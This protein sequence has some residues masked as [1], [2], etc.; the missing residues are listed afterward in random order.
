MLVVKT[1]ETLFIRQVA[2]IVEWVVFHARA[3]ETKVG[4]MDNSD[5]C[6]RLDATKCGRMGPSAFF[7]EELSNPFDGGDCLGTEHAINGHNKRNKVTTLLMTF[8][9]AFFLFCVFRGN[10]TLLWI[11][12]DAG[13]GIKVLKPDVEDGIPA[14]AEQS[15]NQ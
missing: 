1:V 15:T 6:V 10:Q 14:V 13:L 9:Q 7:T 2:A 5:A 11:F 4:G 8:L 12:V 3:T